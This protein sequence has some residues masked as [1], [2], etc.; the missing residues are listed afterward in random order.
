MSTIKSLRLHIGIV[1]QTNAGKSTLLNTITRQN[2]SIVS[3]HPGTTTDPVEKTMELKP[4]GPVL[5]IDTAGYEDH[6][7]MGQSR[8]KKTD[9]YVDRFDIAILVV[10]GVSSLEADKRIAQKLRER[11]IPFCICLANNSEVALKKEWLHWMKEEQI[12]YFLNNLLTSYEE[13]LSGMMDCLQSIIP[14]DWDP[15]PTMISD[16]TNP[17]DI[18]ILVIP[19]DKE[20]PKNR[21]ILPQQQAIRDL[22]DHSS[23]TIVTGVSELA[24]VLDCCKKTPALVVT[25]SQAFKEV[26]AI[27]P[28]HIPVTGFSILLARMKGDLPIFVHG[29]QAIQNLRSGDRVL[30]LEACSHNPVCNDIGR[31]QIPKGI[32]HL[33]KQNIEFDVYSGHDFPDNLT[34][35]KLIIHCGGC[36]LNRK[37]IQHRIKTALHNNVPITNY[38]MVLSYLHGDL[39]RALKILM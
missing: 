7:L 12:P 32:L 36:I 10:D 16:L 31:E 30:I 6:S 37:E 28:L 26:F 39:E 33:T 22:L 29:V 24:T 27:V 4:F 35:Y 13:F 21:I 38:G 14:S 8:Q 25:D 1:G 19:V 17:G 20:A 9:T 15:T 3:M 5:F 23:I 18:V 2:V 11:K 34:D